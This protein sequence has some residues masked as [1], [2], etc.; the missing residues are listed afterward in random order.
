MRSLSI[1]LLLVPL[2]AF[3][4]T[5]T[6][7]AQVTCPANPAG[8]GIDST[9]PASTVEVPCAGIRVVAMDSD[10]DWDD[11]CGAAYT[12]SAG[13]VSFTGDCGDL[14]NRPEVYLR[15]E[16][17]SALGFSVGTHDY[18]LWSALGDAVGL[19]SSS[20]L[21]LPT[22]VLD[23]L[24]SHETYQWLTDERLQSQGGVT[25]YGT[26]R[27][28]YD[29]APRDRLS[30]F[31]ARQ[32]WTLSAVQGRLNATTRH[33]PMDYS[34]TI[35]APIGAPT[36]V[37]D[38]VIIDEDD[39]HTGVTGILW[40]S[41]HEVGH[42]MHNS[43]HGGF[44]EWLSD[45]PAY[46]TNHASCETWHSETFA[47][48]EGFA[49]WVRAL[50]L[51]RTVWP[52]NRVAVPDMSARLTTLNA[53]LFCAAIGSHIEDNVA[54]FLMMATYGSLEQRPSLSQFT[55]PAGFVRRVDPAGVVRCER[56]TAPTCATNRTLRVD[57]WGANDVCVRP[58]VLPMTEA[59]MLRELRVCRADAAPCPPMEVYVLGRCPTGASLV[60]RV[61]QD[62][63]LETIRPIDAA[64]GGAP[65]P[66][67]DGSPDR[68]LARDSG[69]QQ[70]WFPLVDADT[71]IDWV[72]A[73]GTSAHTLA[74]HWT[75]QGRA[76]CAA[77]TPE[78]YPRY[79]S[80]SLSP[81]FRT[82]VAPVGPTFP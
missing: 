25:H 10:P 8:G 36:T 78:G 51:S 43:V 59:E 81:E 61:G 54:G 21:T 74:D 26:V 82:L 41:P 67:G 75:R 17:R 56:L 38:T 57:R 19:I 27:L 32:L 79:C 73:D 47:W 63:C 13:E 37:W 71:I 50:A 9:F 44:L 80:P 16:G 77:N 5:F 53:N 49:H 22:Q 12:N 35:D 20:G 66:R 39:L 4:E 68:A 23:Y 14:T 52:T 58:D 64:P 2:A 46:L 3:A 7:Q 62:T 55:C 48:Y 15:V 18:T 30:R 76:W 60:P 40:A 29:A 34:F 72:A 42:V 24:R 70:R 69:G 6:V 45:V 11:Y 31:A 33:R 1:I 65:L 28:G